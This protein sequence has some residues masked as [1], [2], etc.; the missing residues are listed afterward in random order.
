MLSTFRVIL[1]AIVTLGAAQVPQRPQVPPR[2]PGRP[3]AAQPL[4]TGTAS[5]T[6][7]VLMASGQPARKV[8]VNLSGTAVAGGGRGMAGRSTTTDDQ[9]RFSFTALAAG[10]YSLSAN[11]PG[12]LAV[13]YGQRRPGMPGT[14]I[15]LADGQK[16]EAQLQMP[17]GG[18]LT[19]MVLDEHGEP[20]PG[21]S[22]RALRFRMA[23]GRRTLQM[24][25]SGNT[26]DRGI[27]R[28]YNLEPGDYVVCASPR[29]TAMGDYERMVAE[30][31][32]LRQ[33]LES[34]A[35]SRLPPEQ[36]Q[37]LP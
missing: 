6:G 5:I 18:V 10:R 34:A 2:D 33:A 4:P 11:K 9:G 23:N 20:T 21:T 1:L 14:Q 12:Y 36:I 22:V 35:A 3:G 32:G 13:T 27:Y 17:K 8:R 31:E 37:V 24:A 16:F 26:D 15:Q 30:T 28:L 25:S 29:N 7:V 19:G